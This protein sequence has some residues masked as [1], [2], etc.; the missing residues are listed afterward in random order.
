[1]R[2]FLAIYAVLAL[3]F[4]VTIGIITGG[5]ASAIMALF[6][7]ALVGL[8]IWLVLRAILPTKTE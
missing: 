2:I 4:A 5:T 7:A 8:V 3:A 1:M 6:G